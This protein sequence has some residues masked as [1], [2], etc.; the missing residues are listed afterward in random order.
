MI[1]PTDSEQKERSVAVTLGEVLAGLHGMAEIPGM[2][3]LAEMP[4]DGFTFQIPPCQ[5]P[6]RWKLSDIEHVLA[7]VA[8][9]RSAESTTLWYFGPI[10]F[11]RDKDVMQ[12]YDGQQRLTSML[13]VVSVLAGRLQADGA[14]LGLSEEQAERLRSAAEGAAR[15][16]YDRPA[17]VDAIMLMTERLR[18]RFG[19]NRKAGA[20]QLDVRADAQRVVWML[21]HVFFSATVL[22]SDIEAAQYFQGENNRGASMQLVDLV[23]SL[24]LRFVPEADLEKY[25]ALWTNLAEQRTRGTFQGS[26]AVER[27]LLPSMLI[28]R[29]LWTFEAEANDADDYRHFISGRG[30]FAR[31]RIS[32]SRAGTQGEATFPTL[33]SMPRTGVPFFRTLVW[34]AVLLAAVRRTL[35]TEADDYQQ[36]I[37]GQELEPLLCNGLVYWADAFMTDADG[38][39]PNRFEAFMASALEDPSQVNPDLLAEADIVKECAARLARDP[40]YEGWREALLL[41]METLR[42]LWERLDWRRIV[43]ALALERTGECLLLVPYACGRAEETVAE[44]FR[45]V[46][47][48]PSSMTGPNGHNGDN[49]ESKKE[50]KNHA[51]QVSKASKMVVF[52]LYEACGSRSESIAAVFN[53]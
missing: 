15:F 37:T 13:L 23:K 53:S 34:S 45:R 41:V 28:V 52:D 47:Y 22:R 19:L 20:G 2:P 48:R 33:S 21:D 6:Y 14:N 29:G 12:I 40:A 3:D 31:K 42:L 5:R 7:D 35:D 43:R 27:V 32:D 25:A 50:K 26:D 10:C 36:Y 1:E 51:H 11:R 44:L 30:D 8:D 16:S 24:N 4:P 39:M 9:M 49:E 17:T 38:S 46:R 18:N